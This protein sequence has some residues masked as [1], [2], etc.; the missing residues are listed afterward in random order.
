[1]QAP[2]SVRGYSD[3]FA[4]GFRA[5]ATRI[6][7][8]PG[9]RNSLESIT[10]A[11]ARSRRSFADITH[12]RPRPTSMFVSNTSSTPSE[13]REKSS[14][15][16]RSS[17][18][19]FSS[20]L[21][22]RITSVYGDEN[23]T[24]SSSSRRSSKSFRFFGSDHES[25]PDSG[26]WISTGGPHTPSAPN[27]RYVRHSLSLPLPVAIP[28]TVVTTPN[29][30]DSH[31]FLCL[32]LPPYSSALHQPI[33]PFT[34]SP[35]ARSM[36]IDLSSDSSPSGTPKRESFLSLTGSSSN[37]SSLIFSRRERPTSIHTMPLPSR[38]RRSSLQYRAPSQEK[39]DFF[40]ILEEEPGLA[41]EPILEDERDDW[42]APA[43]IDWRQFHIDILTD[44]SH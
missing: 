19:T 40:L 36:F 43:K 24:I 31:T 17:F 34:S 41:A 27:G 44:D 30:S 1:M 33:D 14:R 28:C 25:V 18:V 9:S 5:V 39:S 20:R 42:D 12:R 16:R 11:P 3:F 6:P 15:G 37:R 21:F 32:S 2:N 26:M 8:S 22:E 35:D 4:S 7:S 38:S 13:T 29:K 23:S 10:N